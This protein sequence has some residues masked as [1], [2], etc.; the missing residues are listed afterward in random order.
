[1]IPWAG[2]GGG[3]ARNSVRTTPDQANHFVT[4]E[5]VGCKEGD[6]QALAGALAAKKAELA[7]EDEEL[8]Q[9]HTQ[10]ASR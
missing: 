9:L 2:G 3:G 7:A 6:R 8:A 4:A 10:L 5:A 1:M